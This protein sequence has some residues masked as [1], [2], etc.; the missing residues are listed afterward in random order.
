L[1]VILAGAL[2]FL[3]GG[4]LSTTKIT[5]T[6]MI[7]KYAYGESS[8]NYENFFSIS[9]FLNQSQLDYQKKFYSTN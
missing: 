7:G 8:D 5:H 4:S 2:L 9:K 6:I 3:L 1:E